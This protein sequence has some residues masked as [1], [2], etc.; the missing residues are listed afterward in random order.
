MIPEI[1]IKVKIEGLSEATSV[2]YSN[3]VYQNLHGLFDEDTVYY[4][5]QMIVLFMNSFMKVIAYKRISTGGISSAIVDNRIILMHALM[6]PG[7]IGMILAHNHPSGNTQPS[8]NDIKRTE[9]LR[10]AGD[11]VGIT[12]HDHII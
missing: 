1:K 12:L 9:H 3:E 5:E 6:V 8:E 4:Q 7:C 11:I 2:Q 10:E